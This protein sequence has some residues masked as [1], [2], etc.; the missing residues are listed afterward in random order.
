MNPADSQPNK[1]I[2]PDVAA[3]AAD[4]AADSNERDAM[5]LLTLA[6]TGIRN[7][8]CRLLEVGDLYRHGTFTSSLRIRPETSKCARQRTIQLTHSY[9]AA[10]RIFIERHRS[11]EE[12]P[13]CHA[14]LFPSTRG[15]GFLTKRGM[16]A[17]AARWTTAAGQRC[18]PHAYRHALATDLM[19]VTSPRVV[20]Q[21]LGHRRLETVMR[22]MHPTVEDHRLALDAVEASRKRFVDALAKGPRS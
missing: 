6:E 10:I 1:L 14:P 5:I 2:P 20:Q 4:L 8:E 18:T 17:V 12:G 11:N 16:I 3:R 21:V 13:L 19:R 7:S 9:Q 22:Y 15:H